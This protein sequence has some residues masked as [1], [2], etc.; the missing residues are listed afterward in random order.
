MPNLIS[1]TNLF[2]DLAFGVILRLR[3]DG[4]TA[5]AAAGALVA[6]EPSKPVHPAAIELVWQF[7]ARVGIARLRARVRIDTG[8]RR[9]N[10]G[11]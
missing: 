4:G 5:P 7:S 6:V 2:G 8:E 9:S 10:S 3:E 1:I 11:A